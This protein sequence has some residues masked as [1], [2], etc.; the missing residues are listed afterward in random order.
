M[1]KERR[2][3]KKEKTGTACE[4]EKESVERQSVCDINKD[5]R[6]GGKSAVRKREQDHTR[7]KR[8]EFETVS[9]E[10]G[11]RREVK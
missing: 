6:R 1:R 3:Y 8:E 2:K 4:P 10:R 9:K 5:E 11:K 7:L